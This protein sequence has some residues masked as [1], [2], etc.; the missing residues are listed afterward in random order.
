MKCGITNHPEDRLRA[1]RK[2]A[3]KFNIEVIELD[4]FK[5]DDGAIPQNCERELLDMKEIRFESNYDISGK[6]EFFEYGALEAI[7]KFIEKW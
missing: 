2:N 5:F 4:V 6:S 3:E 7:R 1:L